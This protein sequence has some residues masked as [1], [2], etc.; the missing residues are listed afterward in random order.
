METPYLLKLFNSSS[1]E[2]DF[3]LKYLKKITEVIIYDKRSIESI[4]EW[5]NCFSL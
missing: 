5:R 2:I 1:Y 4:E 3:Y